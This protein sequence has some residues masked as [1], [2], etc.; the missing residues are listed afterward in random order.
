MSL[1]GILLSQIDETTHLLEKARHLPSKLL[2]VKNEWFLPFICQGRK[3]TME[4]PVTTLNRELASVKH[5]VQGWWDAL[6]DSRW[7]CDTN[8]WAI[9]LIG[10]D[11][12]LQRLRLAAQ[13]HRRDVNMFVSH[14]HFSK[15]PFLL[16]LAARCKISTVTP[17]GVALDWWPPVLL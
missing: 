8:G 9:A 13:C 17:A 1:F 4:W 11:K 2:A 14:E 3:E 6:L 15:T 10:F 7:I 16:F 12:C 5:V